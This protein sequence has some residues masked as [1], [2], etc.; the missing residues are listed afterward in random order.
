VEKLVSVVKKLFRSSPLNNF[1]STSQDMESRASSSFSINVSSNL[2]TLYLIRIIVE[3]SGRR[4]FVAASGHSVSHCHNTITYF[5]LYQKY[6][7][8]I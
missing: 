2:S 8:K 6:K 4:K 7:I 1:L 5:V 3:R